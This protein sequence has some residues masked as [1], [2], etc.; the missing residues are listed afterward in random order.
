M[1]FPYVECENPSGK[2]WVI[3]ILVAKELFYFS[4]PFKLSK[5]F[6]YSANKNDLRLKVR[7]I[8]SL[9][10]S[11]P[12][13]TLDLEEFFILINLRNNQLIKIKKNIIQLLNELA[14]NNIIQN[15]V[16]IVLKSGK[17][18]DQLIQNLTLSDITRRIKYIKFY[19]ILR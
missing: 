3:E 19:E 15:A 12:E 7:I 4:Y 17:K 10:V 11:K 2:L 5:S 8:K 1:W 9:A 13:K 16:E 18:K 14:E 6:L